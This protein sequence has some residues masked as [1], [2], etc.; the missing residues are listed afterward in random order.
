MK[1]IDFIREYFESETEGFHIKDIK[2]VERKNS[3]LF[4][5][6]AIPQIT[7]Q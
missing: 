2:M 7:A 3:Y 6:I 5:I 4:S 1:Q